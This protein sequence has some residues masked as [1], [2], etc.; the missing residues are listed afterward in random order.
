MACIRLLKNVALPQEDDDRD[1][2]FERDEPVKEDPSVE[3]QVL[4]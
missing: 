2:D 1:N 4:L 3:M